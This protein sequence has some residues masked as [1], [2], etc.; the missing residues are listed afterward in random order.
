MLFTS[1]WSVFAH[2]PLSVHVEFA[3]LHS[4]WAAHTVYG[5]LTF[6]VSA[7]KQ[8]SVTRPV[9]G[10]VTAE[11]KLFLGHLSVSEATLESHQLSPVHS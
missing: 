8:D 3:L 7:H 5:P 9:V 2:Q 11:Q 4:C 1:V 6:D 10:D